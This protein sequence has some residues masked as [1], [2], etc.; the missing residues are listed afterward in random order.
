VRLNVAVDENGQN[1]TNIAGV[2][3]VDDAVELPREQFV[4]L[5]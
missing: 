4:L 2:A 5:K 1:E 3:D